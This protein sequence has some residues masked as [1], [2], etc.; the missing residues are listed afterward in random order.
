M[1]W[2]QPLPVLGF[3]QT[4]DQPINF[5]HTKHAAPVEEGG[6]G[7]DCTYC[8]RTVAKGCLGSIPAVE[9]CASCHRAVGSYESEDLFKL[10][11]FRN[12][13]KF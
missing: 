2:G 9:L 13:R 6:I 11:L 10:E 8:H 12:F 1:V 5:P 4:F 3:K 7:M